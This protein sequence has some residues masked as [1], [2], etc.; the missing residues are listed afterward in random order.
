MQYILLAHSS[1]SLFLSFSL[2]AP[3]FLLLKSTRA[4][5]ILY[6]TIFEIPKPLSLTSLEKLFDGIHKFDIPDD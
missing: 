5:I 4:W 2:S 6:S 3:P 1:F